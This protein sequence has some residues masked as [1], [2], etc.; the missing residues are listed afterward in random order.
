M[1][2][3]ELKEYCEKKVEI[4]KGWQPLMVKNLAVKSMKDIN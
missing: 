1:T 4:A 3:E 2:R